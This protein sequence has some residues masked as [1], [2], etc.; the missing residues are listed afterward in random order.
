M[1]IEFD[2]TCFIKIEFINQWFFDEN[3]PKTIQTFTLKLIASISFNTQESGQATFTVHSGHE[4]AEYKLLPACRGWE[5]V[6][7]YIVPMSSHGDSCTLPN[8]ACLASLIVT[9][10]L[11]RIATTVSQ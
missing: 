9:C 5:R 7:V 6:L 1:Y 8:I 2:L 3:R 10:V 4:L 11:Y